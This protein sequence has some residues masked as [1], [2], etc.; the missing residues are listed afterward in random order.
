MFFL[1][2]EIMRAPINLKGFLTKCTISEIFILITFFLYKLKK[3]R[4]SMS[5]DLTITP[6]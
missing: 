6:M 3:G 4:V 5:S 1:R 2:I